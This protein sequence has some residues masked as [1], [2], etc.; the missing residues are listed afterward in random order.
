LGWLGLDFWRGGSTGTGAGE[1]AGISA[2]L[3]ELP[4]EHITTISI[5]ELGNGR[6]VVDITKTFY[7][8]LGKTSRILCSLRTR[9]LIVIDRP[10][11]LRI[12]NG[13]NESQALIPF[14][15]GGT[16]LITMLFRLPSNS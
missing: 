10:D 11:P 14:S 9:V 2:A 6:L 15:V 13:T 1:F 5:T 12:C 16:D 7:T 8:V 3:G 4:V